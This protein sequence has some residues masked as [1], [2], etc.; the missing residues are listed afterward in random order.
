MSTGVA[1]TRR[2]VCGCRDSP[3]LVGRTRR[4]PAPLRTGRPWRHAVTPANRPQPSTRYVGSWHVPWSIARRYGYPMRPIRPSAAENAAR[5]DELEQRLA[6]L[7][8]Q[9]RRDA[10]R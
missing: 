3:Q 9:L 6:E 5:V 7:E 2:S 4:R 10:T 8:A 1:W